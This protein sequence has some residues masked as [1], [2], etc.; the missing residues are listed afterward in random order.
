MKKALNALILLGLMA[1]QVSAEEPRP[2]YGAV[3]GALPYVQKQLQA[4][5]A[6][7]QAVMKKLY[8]DAEK[9]L[10]VEPPSVVEKK[11]VPPSGNL[12]DYMSLAPYFWPDPNKPKGVPYIRKDGQVNPESRQLDANDTVRVRTLGSAVETLAL[13]YYFSH[14]EKYAAQAAKFLKVWFLDEATRMNP[15]LNYA[16]AVLGVNDGREEGVLE[17]MSIMNAIDV[18]TLLTGSKAWTATEQKALDQWTADYLKWL[19]TSTLGQKEGAAKNNHGTWYDVQ[20]TRLALCLGQ[21]ELAQE[22]IRTALTKRLATQIEPDGRQPLE[23]ARTTSLGYSSYNLKAWSELAIVGEHVQVDVWNYKTKDG[24]SL[25]AAFDFLLPYLGENAKPWPYKQ[26][27]D[28]KPENLFIAMRRAS[29]VWSVP[30][31]EKL[32][33]ELPKSDA[34]RF[35]LMVPLG[36]TTAPS[37]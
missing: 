10:S 6:S 26:I 24:R 13:A 33:S 29:Q 25:R 32:L 8:A 19:Q 27:H 28:A 11:K 18:T 5:D 21:K 31:Y 35:Q 2:Y 4:G 22:T 15:H 30:A 12:H 37:R 14:E 16:Q 23:L 9:T 20:K 3:P 7:L 1:L 17:G 36:L 34:K